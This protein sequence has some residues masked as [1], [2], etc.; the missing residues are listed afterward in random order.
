MKDTVSTPSHRPRRSTSAEVQTRTSPGWLAVLMI[1][2][3]L[4]SS[5]A[6]LPPVSTSR[7]PSGR[8]AQSPPRSLSPVRILFTN[9]VEGTIDPCG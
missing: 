8:Q 6:V 9:D 1:A 2:A 5:C 4:L 7:A 3:L